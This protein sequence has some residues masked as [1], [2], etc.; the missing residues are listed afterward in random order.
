MTYPIY[1]WTRP[2]DAP[3]DTAHTVV[4][5]Y[6]EGGFYKLYVFRHPSSMTIFM[7][8]IITDRLPESL[9]ET[10][11][12]AAPWW[13]PHMYPDQQW[14]YDN[15]KWVP[16]DDI[17]PDPP[18][19]PAFVTKVLETC[20]VT[21]HYGASNHVQ[22]GAYGVGRA[23]GERGIPDLAKVQERLNYYKRTMLAMPICPE[24]GPTVRLKAVVYVDYAQWRA[25]A[26][27]KLSCTEC[28]RP[29]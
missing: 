22:I 7:S 10:A 8:A 24:H 1:A 2:N 23:G 29:S 27:I 15:E 4:K 13:A 6:V 25:T 5:R 14:D 11:T 9:M 19:V 16:F 26:T 17:D 20:D 12:K 28:E 18:Q 21:D 3:K